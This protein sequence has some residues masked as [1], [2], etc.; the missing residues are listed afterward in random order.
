M[1]ARRDDG[2][3]GAVRIV[4]SALLLHDLRQMADVGPP[5]AAS[6]SAADPFS[7]GALVTIEMSQMEIPETPSLALRA[8]ALVCDV[9]DLVFDHLELAALEARRAGAGFAQMVGAAVVI[10]VLWVTAWL[11]LVAGAIVWA[12]SAGIPFAGALAIA[13]II[14]VIAGVVLAVWVRRQAG[15][16]LFPATLRQLKHD[17]AAPSGEIS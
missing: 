17:V 10:S 12:T 2:A 1:C 15:E 7:V 4:V 8:K 13:A 3:I 6:C 5:M 16:L 11:A 9:R 14:N